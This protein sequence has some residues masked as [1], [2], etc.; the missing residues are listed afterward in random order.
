[1]KT[2]TKGSIF[3]FLFISLQCFSMGIALAGDDL[4]AEISANPN[5]VIMYDAESLSENNVDIGDITTDTKG[6][7]DDLQENKPELI[8]ETV[9][10][11][12]YPSIDLTKIEVYEEKLRVYLNDGETK[13]AL[14]ELDKVYFVFW[15]DYTPD[16][17]DLYI[18]GIFDGDTAIDEMYA[19]DGKVEGDIEIKSE[20]FELEIGK[21]KIDSD[22]VY[23]EHTVVAMVSEEAEDDKIIID[24]VSIGGLDTTILLWIVGGAL[25]VVAVVIIVRQT[26]RYQ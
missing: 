13:K 17:D 4:L 8:Y 10:S 9:S 7:Y 18:V 2:I 3:L 15:T 11:E 19:I 5:D 24:I 14:D 1:M 25:V 22:Y 26:Q 12:D 20:Y 23:D 21:D 16:E 6:F